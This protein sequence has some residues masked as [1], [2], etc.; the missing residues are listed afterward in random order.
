MYPLPSTQ[1]KSSKVP[2]S[3]TPLSKHP[4]DYVSLDLF[5]PLPD[6][7]SV[8]VS[9]CNFSRFPAVKLVKSTRAEHVLLALASIYSNF[10]NSK[11]HKADNGP[12]FNCKEFKDFSAQRGISAIHSYPYHPQGNEAECF[13]KPL[14]KAIKIVLDTQKPVQQATGDLLTDYRST[15]HV[16]TGITP[17]I[18][19]YVEVIVLAFHLQDSPYK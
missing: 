2:L 1:H 11:E 10:G 15:P 8:L 5:G 14:G 12:P 13:M 16:A 19:Y 9:R 3:S 4:W 7:S 17:L 18:C 6:H